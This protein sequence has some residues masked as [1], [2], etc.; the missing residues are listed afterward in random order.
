MRK[1]LVAIAL[2][3]IVA[4]CSDDSTGPKASVE[5]VYNLQT[6][7]GRPLPV[8]LIGLPGYALQEIS[9]SVTLNGNLTFVEVHR[10]RETIE[11]IPNNIVTDTTVT[12]N[13]T[14]EIE[15]DSAI[16]LTTQQDGSVLF[17]V[18]SGGRLTLHYEPESS[19]SLFTYFY[20]K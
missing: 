19:D 4:A 20:R 3:G 11:N 9:G 10:L 6:I 7:N 1:L 2:S 13:G 15:Q 8:T 12:L 14:Y 5:G 18:V 16:L 17:G